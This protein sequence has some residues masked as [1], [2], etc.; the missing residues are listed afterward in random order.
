[1]SYAPLPAE[2]VL[3]IVS[4]LDPRDPRPLVRLLYTSRR[5]HTLLSPLLLR[6]AK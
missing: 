6:E 1:M 4:H 2:L 3:R 5:N